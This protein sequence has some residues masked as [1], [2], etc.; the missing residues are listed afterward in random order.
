[1]GFSALNAQGLSAPPYFLSFLMCNLTAWIADRTQQRGLV[2][3]TLC[4]VGGVGYVLL[5]TCESLAIRYFGIFLAAAG[6][7]PAISNILA[8][9]LN[10][11]GT[12]TK[13]GVGY[14]LLQTVGQCGPLL[15]TRLYPTSEG[16]RYI[17]GQSICA[18]FMFLCALLALLLR[19]WLSRQNK[20]AE[21]REIEAADVAGIDAK[22]VNLAIENDGYGFRNVL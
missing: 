20:E 3:I 2:I 11:Q 4:L 18:A 1:M 15:G 22:G 12:D 6:I 13:R 14:S 19:T 10:N 21:K 9:V 7:F 8:W 16:P 5:A 17:K